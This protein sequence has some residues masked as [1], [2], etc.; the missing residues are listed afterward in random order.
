MSGSE[1]W[2]RNVQ[3]LLALESVKMYKR[4]SLFG[5]AKS[6]TSQLAETVEIMASEALIQTLA[7]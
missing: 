2:N 5:E 4:L 1:R 6:L 3:R 7:G